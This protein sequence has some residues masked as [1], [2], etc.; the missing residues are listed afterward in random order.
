MLGGRNNPLDLVDL[1]QNGKKPIHGVYDFLILGSL[2]LIHQGRMDWKILTMEVNEAREAG[3]KCQEDYKRLFPGAIAEVRKWFR[4][5]EISE[6]KKENRFIQEGE[7]LSLNQTM[8]IIIETSSEYKSL[9][10]MYQ[11]E[12]KDNTWLRMEKKQ[13]L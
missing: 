9:M 6:G 11:G 1:G 7:I 5:Y 13:N 2:G 3:V 8:R 12:R 4:D 10:E